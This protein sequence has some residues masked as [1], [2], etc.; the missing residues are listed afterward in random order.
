[1]EEL[2]KITENNSKQVQVIYASGY[3]DPSKKS[4]KK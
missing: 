2:I 3:K 1:M 4:K